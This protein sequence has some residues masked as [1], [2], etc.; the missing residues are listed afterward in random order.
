MISGRKLQCMKPAIMNSVGLNEDGSGKCRPPESRLHFTCAQSRPPGLQRARF[1]CP[2]DS[3]SKNTGVDGYALLGG[4]FL[5]QGLNLRLLYLLPR[6]ADA[7]PL[8]LPGS[9]YCT[10]SSANASLSSVLFSFLWC[11]RICVS[12]FFLTFTS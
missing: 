4:I 11:V 5:T 3:P 9:P 2:W 1:L 12:Y 6:R 7:L 8:E 10:C